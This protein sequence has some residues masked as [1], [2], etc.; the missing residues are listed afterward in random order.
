MTSPTKNHGT[1]KVVELARRREKDSPFERFGKSLPPGKPVEQIDALL[2]RHDAED[3]IKTINPHALFRLIKDAGFDQGMDLIPYVAP[4][5][6]QLFLDLDCWKKDRIDTTRM[7]AWLAVIVADAD[8]AHFHAAIRDM[9]PEVIA[10]FFKK[11]FVAVEPIEDEDQ[12]IPDHMPDNAVLS[13]DNAYALVYPEDQDIAALLRA[14][15]DRLYFVDPGLAWAL[16]EAVRWELESQMEETAYRFRTSRIE[17]YGFVDRT[18]ALAV[19]ARVDPVETRTRFE[20]GKL[21]AKPIL[22]VAPTLDLPAV[23]S[24]N[25]DES[26]FFF[27]ILSS[28]DDTDTVQRLTAELIALNNRTM[29]AD[30]IE[31]GEI[32]TGQEVVQ[33]T[34]GFLSLGLEFLSR[35]VP[36][37]AQKALELIP[38]RR[39]FQVGY[40]ITLDLQQK[41][42]ALKDRPTLTLVAGELY[43]LLNPDERA[44]FE[45]LADLRPSFAEDRFTFDIFREQA[46]VDQAALALGLIAFKQLWLFGVLGQKVEDLATMLYEGAVQ[47]PPDMVSFDALFATALVTQL[48]HDKSE[49]RGLT[50]NELRVLPEVLAK[51]PWGDDPVGYF[52]DLIAPI[53]MKLPAATTG[54][55][56]RWLRQTLDL[57]TEELAGVTSYLGPEPFL[58]LLL[59]AP[60]IA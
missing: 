17:E 51:A 42:N 25:V 4:D 28:I 9:D 3:Y 27:Q 56:T 8:D 5:Q 40:S 1:E 57:L 21:A 29:I 14:L 60:E 15:V 22:A 46:Q 16:F 18:E 30:G 59:V 58:E 7:A 47:N 39:I 49:L 44:L 48:L 20:E 35:A 37:E 6:L 23:V 55:A 50:P 2:E 10:L 11:N 26:F 38:L 31:P 34:T 33:R 45:G 52:E 13:P 24:E 19:Y 54:L 43:S 41:A 12:G 32:E 36:E 53:L